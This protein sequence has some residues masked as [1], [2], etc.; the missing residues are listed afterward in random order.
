MTHT[1]AAVRTGHTTMSVGAADALDA[2]SFTILRQFPPPAENATR[3]GADAGTGLLFALTARRIQPA[4]RQELLP[5]LRHWLMSAT[6]EV[7]HYGVFGN[8]LSGFVVGLDHAAQVQP[9]LEPLA[10]AAR[11]RLLDWIHRS[12][13]QVKEI[14]WADYDLIYGPSGNALVLCAAATPASQLAPLR[15]QLT[16]LCTPGLPGLRV[17]RRH[18]GDPQDFNLHRVNTGLGHGVPGVVAALCALIRAC[19]P[20]PDLLLALDNAAQFLVRACYRDAH[21]VLS[22]RPMHDASDAA[23]LHAR[24]QVW[25]YGGPG[26]SWALWDAAQLL[27]DASLAEFG[28]AA[29]GSLCAAW[30]GERY[31]LERHPGSTLCICHGAAGVLS[32][33]DAFARHAGF[34]PAARLRDHL[35]E[36]LMDRLPA[37]I[38]LAEVDSTMLTGASG[39]LAALDLVRGGPRSWLCQ[40]GLR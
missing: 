16:A 24:E 37:I 13:W 31:L 39:V 12:P 29:V 36:Y 30:D 5:G 10:A 3:R 40:L 8:G 34:A 23:P 21:G 9:E 14:D 1:S 27:G 6:G 18:S 22:W 32:V 20:A 28:L 38:A 11:D 7:S 15:D 19:G 26:V 25:C 4:E 35:F 2:A 17:G 33:A